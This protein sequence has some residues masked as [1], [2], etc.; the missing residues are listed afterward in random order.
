MHGSRVITT[1]YGVHVKQL[2]PLKGGSYKTELRKSSLFSRLFPSVGFYSAL[3]RI[4]LRSSSRA[5]RGAYGDKEWAES[6]YEVMQHLENVGIDF[7]ISGMDNLIELEGP[8]VFI[9][10][11]MSALE[12]FVLPC[13]IEPVKDVTF[14]VKQG[15][16]DYPVFRYVMRSRDPILVGRTNPREDLRAVLEGGTQI[17]SRGRSLVIFPQTT[18]TPIFDPKEFNTIGIKLAKRA[19]VPVVPIALKTDS[20]GNGRRLKDFG[21]IDPSHKVHFSFGKPLI[22]K[23]RGVEEHNAIIAFIEERLQ[24]WHN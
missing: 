15:L 10:N 14:V 4:V 5:K 24:E 16:I 8:C 7:E 6:S 22:I 13:I 3:T 18:R 17:L 1:E 23:D 21:K 12:T 9:G 2:I 19:N 20:W 11:H